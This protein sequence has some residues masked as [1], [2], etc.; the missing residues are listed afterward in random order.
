MF[1]STERKANFAAETKHAVM[2]TITSKNGLISVTVSVFVYK[3]RDYPDGDMFVVY[4]P[5]LN[6]CGYD[7]T[8]EKAIKEFVYILKEYIREQG[9]NG[10]LSE[11]LK[12]HGWVKSE[13]FLSE[14]PFS[15]LIMADDSLRDIMDNCYPSK[16]S[17]NAS[18]FLSILPPGQ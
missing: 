7:D 11:D 6:L 10:T 3:D 9:E 12:R 8:C 18:C 17:I 14:P 13:E 1:D 16:V 2:N 5:S 4:C 15:T